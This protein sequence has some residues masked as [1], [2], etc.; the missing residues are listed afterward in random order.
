[1]YIIH[2]D[3]IGNYV[4]Y[5]SV[6]LPREDRMAIDQRRGKKKLTHFWDKRIRANNRDCF[7]FFGDSRNHRDPSKANPI[8]RNK[9]K[10]TLFFEEL[11]KKE[12][13]L[14]ETRIEE[15]LINVLN[16]GALQ[17]LNSHARRG[18]RSSRQWWRRRRVCRKEARH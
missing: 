5:P 9:V 16:L 4:S 8:Q 13:S 12:R 7:L 6:I 15:S 1:M 18:K 3:H 14:R 2:S 11:R 10:V 17:N